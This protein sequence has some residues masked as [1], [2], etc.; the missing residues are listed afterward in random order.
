MELLPRLPTTPDAPERCVAWL[1]A[2]A[3]DRDLTRPLPPGGADTEA[4]RRF[5]DA[6]RAEMLDF[7]GLVDAASES[8]ALNARQLS[9]V[10]AATVEHG[11]V[12][13]RTA[14]A[15]AEI[16][17]GAAHV[18][19]TADALRTRSAGLA[20]STGEYDASAEMLLGRL[21]TLLASIE[22][23][24]SFASQME[25]GSAGIRDFLER[26]KRIARQ[27]RLLAINAAIE[28]AHL[29]EIGR[30]F[31]IVAEEVKQL[32]SS[33]AD[34]AGSV[35]TIEQQLRE[36]SGDVETAIRTSSGF[37]GG[38]AREIAAARERSRETRS[39]VAE[40]EEAISAVAAIAAE[41][42][43]SLSQ[44]AHGV[45]NVAARA[46]EVAEASERAA[47]LAIADAI[48]RLRAA[49]ARYRLGE[50]PRDVRAVAAEDLPEAFREAA[51]ALRTRLDED[52]REILLLV[53]GIAVSIARNSYEWRAIA[54]GLVA[55]GN[56][57][58]GTTHAI[59]E[60]AAGATSA[61]AA[62]QQ[63]RSSLA[64]LRDGFS[65]SIDELRHA[66]ERV[67]HVR[68]AVQR[69]ESSVRTTADAAG[70][71]TGILEM[72]DTIAGETSLLSLN[73]AIEAAHAGAAG[74]GFGIIADEIRTLADTT[75]QATQ[76]ISTLIGDLAGAS[77][78]MTATTSEAVAQTVAIHDGASAMH[79]AVAELRT[80]LD[81][82]VD[83]TAEVATIVEQQL[84]ALRDLRDATQL[85]QQRVRSDSV[86]A[87]DKRRLELAMLGMRAHALA[88]RRPLG[89]V[90][91][92]V[93][94][95]GGLVAEEMDRVF[96]TAI[97]R[98]AL[99][100]DDC[101][102]TEYVELTGTAIAKLG[103]LFDVSKVPPSGFTPPKYETRYDRAVEDGFNALI[104]EY[105]P[106]H[107]KIAA[108]F[109]VDLN[110]FCFGHYRACRQ[111]WTGD[112]RRDLDN[113]RIKRFFDD[114]LS[115]RCSRVG[116]G[117]AADALPAR[118]PYATFRD[119]GCTLDREGQ[120]PW[121]IFTYARDTGVVYNDL[122]VALYARDRRVGTIRIIYD[123]DV[124]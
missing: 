45:D 124:V 99:R 64:A 9:E 87:T 98:G 102:D 72:I 104:D 78:S 113:N 13:E 123:A 20:R 18:A 101:F 112:P 25:S 110:G 89:T 81:R 85:A 27:A 108:M 71:A 54:E 19:Q 121:A 66:L 2:A 77:G 83:Q 58:D 70:R 115:L 65:V 69:A 21:Q 11:A 88:A 74:N 100:L 46:R 94:A 79:G 91:E 90:A 63:M 31:T 24:A 84:A 76:Q 57:L 107:P 53:T 62:A 28:A 47:R 38:I 33:T 105:V 5:V 119:R 116:L 92:E 114:E 41:Q 48:D 95:V 44:I 51:A 50:R 59:D 120:R 109:A 15:I 30:G 3:R 73:A 34:S 106:R 16:D 60:T 111:D 61:A 35:A 37:V 97:A 36:A 86:A 8:A 49:I 7:A 14:S 67:A 118:T 96:E 56:E 80:D 22:A 43:A 39:Q 68:D 1:A 10:A 103:R 26:L 117:P 6:L 17:R 32:A 12:V 122:S 40:L 93:R 75:S 29:G 4:L 42:S 82:T 23:A 52:Q 55:L